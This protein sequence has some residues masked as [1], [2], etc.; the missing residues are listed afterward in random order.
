MNGLTNVSEEDFDK[1]VLM[2]SIPVVV[3]FYADWCG[4]CR[5]LEPI[6]EMLAKKFEGTVKFVRVD[7]DSNQD[8]AAQYN[9]VSIPTV[10]FFS[11]G[12]IRDVVIGAAPANVYLA[13]I[14]KLLS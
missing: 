3:D 7:V 13:R 10:I 2:S 5:V 11:K 9:V 8:L 1:E 12:K 14:E 6:M 4:P